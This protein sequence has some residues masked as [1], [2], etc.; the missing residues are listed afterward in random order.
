MKDANGIPQN[1]PKF[2]KS[3]VNGLKV[4]GLRFYIVIFWPFL[5]IFPQKLG[6]SFHVFNLWLQKRSTG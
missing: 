6:S 1:S 4:K 3:G 2:P 5:G